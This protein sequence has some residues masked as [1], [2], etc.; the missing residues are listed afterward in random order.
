ML[1]TPLTGGRGGS[2]LSNEDQSCCFYHP[3]KQAS[4][5]CDTCGRFLCGLCDLQAGSAHICG[6]C[7]QRAMQESTASDDERLC[8]R[9]PTYDQAAMT[10]AI[11]PITAPLGVYYALRHWNTPGSV[12]GVR[13]GLLTAAGIVG[14]AGTVFWGYI[15]VKLITEVLFG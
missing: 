2:D 1:V 4:A 15:A 10:L 6:Q 12:L 3:Q 5:A 11:I 13:R 8:P 14:A 9:R 7:L